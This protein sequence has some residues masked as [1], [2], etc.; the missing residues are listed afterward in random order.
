MEEFNVVS[1]DGSF[2]QSILSA[3][4]EKLLDDSVKTYR[5]CGLA[6]SRAELSEIVRILSAKGCGCGRD[7]EHWYFIRDI[8]GLEIQYDISHP[9]GVV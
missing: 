4:K 2:S 1:V 6:L 7:I 8:Y 9:V 3:V 5:I